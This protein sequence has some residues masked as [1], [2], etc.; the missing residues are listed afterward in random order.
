[1]VYASRHE[2][3]TG[4]VLRDLASGEES[5]LAY[6][7]QRDEQEAIPSR[8]A[9][10]GMSFTPDSR[11]VVATYGGKIWR[12]PIDGRAPIPVPFRVQSKLEL[13]PEVAFKYPISDSTEFAVRQIRDV[14]PSPD[15]KRLAFIALDRL[16][17]VDYPNGTP[18]RLT[19]S[20]AIE[21]YPA[22]SPDG[23]WVGFTTW[24][25]QGGLVHKVKADGTAPPVPLTT[26]RA[27]YQQLAWAPDGSRLVALKGPALAKRLEDG[28][29]AFGSATEVVS[30]PAAGG[31]PNLIMP[32]FGRERPHFTRDSTRIF[33]WAGDSGLVSVRWDGT[34]EKKYLKVTQ[35]LLLNQ[36]KPAAPDL[37]LMSPDG[38]QALIESGYDLYVVTVP[39]VGGEPPTV[40]IQDPKTSSVPARRLTEIGG[41]FPAWSSDGRKVHWNIGP[42]HVVY[43]LDSALAFDRRIEQE[44]KTLESDTSKAGR[45]R[46]DSLGKLRFKPAEARLV[47]KVNRDIPQGTAVLRGARVVTMKGQEVIDNADIVVRNNRI[48]S[49][50]PRGE[51]PSG[52]RVVDVSG[53]TIVPGFVDTHSHMWPAWGLHKEQP[54]MYLANLAYGVTTTRDPQTSSSD[55]LSYEDAVDAGQMIGPRIY[56]TGP[57]V[58]YWLEQIRDLEHAKQVLRRYSDY[59]DTK[60]IKMYVKGNRQT[61][62][63][64]IMAAKETRIMPTTEGSLD[65]E[66]DL[67]MLIDGYPGQEHAT[68][69]V[70]LYRDVVTAYAKSGIEYTPTLLV[71]YGGP[72]AEN[73]FF[74]KE[75]PYNDAK[76]RRFMPYEELAAKTRRRG[77]GAGGWFMD[78]EYIFSRTAKVAADIVKAGGRIGIGSHGEFQGLGYH[79]E[80]WAMGSGGMSNLDVL[81]MA[82]LSGAQSL[83]LDGDLG[84]LEAGKLADLVVLDKNP[85]DSLRNT[86]SIKYV[87]KNGRLYDGNTLDEIWPRQRKLEPPFGLTE[88]PKVAA[89]L[90]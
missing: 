75:L 34:D 29:S 56:S 89:G 25:R 71:Q 3:E 9:Y 30:I 19:K 42:A 65:T 70:P 51:A 35:P 67:T 13:G 52:A 27:T 22:W 44:K 5:W 18:R 77:A 69:T 21:A 23:Q 45:A 31:T 28:P 85:L 46:V 81:R 11:E 36:E 49:V 60:Y 84:S 87:M 74:E 62:Q 33:L 78:E 1:M 82:T 17:L 64:I 20:T 8:D 10:P 37:V 12:I 54:W 39:M 55:V 72:W 43:D 90:R 7:V 66:Y 63:W 32:T 26:V 24:E 50:G 4:L 73:Y 6:P 59:Y 2:A 76:I 38:N 53:K 83:G 47:V 58:G 48:V 16:Y 57:G 40:S 61:R 68:P 80:L 14:A 15:G 88:P 79:W 41:E 86:N